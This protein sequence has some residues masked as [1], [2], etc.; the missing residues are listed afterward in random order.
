MGGWEEGREV[1]RERSHGGSE[2]GSMGDSKERRQLSQPHTYIHKYTHTKKHKHTHTNTHTDIYT[3]KHMNTH[4]CMDT[5][6][7]HTSMNAHMYGCTFTYTHMHTITC[8][9]AHTHKRIY[10]DASKHIYNIYVYL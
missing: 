7:A 2:S 5:H 4:T 8:T 9:R 10:T 6:S 3:C 1:E